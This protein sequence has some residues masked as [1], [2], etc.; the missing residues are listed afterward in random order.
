MS[1]VDDVDNAGKRNCCIERV[2]LRPD[3]ETEESQKQGTTD[4]TTKAK[5]VTG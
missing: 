1:D 4:K 3:V 5:A 2:G